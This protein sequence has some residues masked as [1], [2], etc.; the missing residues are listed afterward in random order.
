M[1][2]NKGKDTKPEM[3][4]RRAL[5]ALGYRYRLHRADLPGRPDIVFPGRRAVVEIRGC[6]WH[7]HPEPV[8]KK[9][10]VPATRR[11]WWMAKLKR[12]VARDAENVTTLEAAG[13]RVSVVWEC[14][15]QRDPELVWRRLTEFLGPAGPS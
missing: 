12:N 10:T 9:A 13:W 5:H 1:R 8:C 2:A 7:Q 15:L 6:F 14:E 11:E 3:K 4:V